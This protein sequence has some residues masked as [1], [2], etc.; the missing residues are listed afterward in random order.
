MLVFYTSGI[1]AQNATPAVTLSHYVLDSFTKG[2]VLL[3]SGMVSEQ[4]LNY[5]ILTGEMIF[6]AGGKYLAIAEPES[7]E[8]VFIRERQFVPVNNRFY[9]LLT[10]TASPL[11]VEFTYTIEQPGSSLGYEMVSN[12]TASTSLKT[13][14]RTGGAYDLKLPGN[15]KIK[16]GYAYWI[17]K[18][19]KYQKAYNAQQISKVF[20]DKKSLLNTLL[21]KS[22]SNL[23][24]K[25]HIIALVQQLQQ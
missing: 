11:F 10:H 15:F 5:N 25:E 16:P 12:T 6:D 24:K 21:K 23:S 19:G 9:E 3:K 1:N 2:K 13:L 18:E 14:I 17:L 4:T 7:V 22:H 8:T 20:P